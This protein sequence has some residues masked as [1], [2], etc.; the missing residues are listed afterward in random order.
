MLTLPRRFHSSRTPSM[1]HT[2]SIMN[3]TDI[4]NNTSAVPLLY[5]LYSCMH[6][7]AV[8]L[9]SCRLKCSDV[10]VNVPAQDLDFH[11]FSNRI[12]IATKCDTSPAR[13]KM[14]IVFRLV[15]KTSVKLLTGLTRPLDTGHSH[16]KLCDCK[17]MTSG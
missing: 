5:I 3:L 6:T 14:F 16:N 1:M 17:Q 7:A 11:I 2:P 13:R 10:R 12:R 4:Y 9:H 15:S 8:R